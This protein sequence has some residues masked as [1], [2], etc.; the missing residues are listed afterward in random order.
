MVWQWWW[1]QWQGSWW[2]YFSLPQIPLPWFLAYVYKIGEFLC[3]W[4]PLR[5]HWRKFYVMRF[6]SSPKIQVR[7][8]PSVGIL[9]RLS[10]TNIVMYYDYLRKIILLVPQKWF[11][12][13]V[14]YDNAQFTPQIKLGEKIACAI[15]LPMMRYVDTVIFNLLQKA[16]QS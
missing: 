3:V 4:D 16:T 13:I 15:K 6:I 7:W 1:W 14:L 12:S 5:S 2:L 11:D 9:I 8:G 10:C